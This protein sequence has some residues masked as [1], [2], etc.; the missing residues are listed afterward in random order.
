MFV[1]GGVLGDRVDCCGDVS[2][3]VRGGQLCGWC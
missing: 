3:C 2:G 1:G